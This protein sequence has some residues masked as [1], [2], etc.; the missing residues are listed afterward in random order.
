M[1]SMK[2]FHKAIIFV[3]IAYLFAQVMQNKQLESQANV[4]TNF[5]LMERQALEEM[6]RA[7]TNPQAYRNLLKNFKRYYNGKLLSVPNQARVLTKEGT[8][9][10]DDAVNFLRNVQPMSRLTI[11]QGLNKATKDH[12]VDQG[13]KGN[14]GHAGSDRSQPSD[15]MSRYGRWEMVAGENIAYGPPTGTQMIMQLIIDDGVPDRGHRTN[16]FNPAYRVTGISCGN[17]RV[18]R[19]MCV[20]N[21]AG[22]YVDRKI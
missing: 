17:H 2:F 22:G 4:P 12:V 20:I 7:R 19:V 9:A 3:A 8:V 15:R 18:F 13:I 14:L 10:V 11:V 5:R 1:K 21:Y 16:I 6:N